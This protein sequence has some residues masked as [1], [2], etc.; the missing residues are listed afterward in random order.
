MHHYKQEIGSLTLENKHPS[1]I[2]LESVTFVSMSV[3]MVIIQ[4]TFV[5]NFAVACMKW[6]KRLHK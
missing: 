6:E 1:P 2:P 5:Y 3:I 4:P